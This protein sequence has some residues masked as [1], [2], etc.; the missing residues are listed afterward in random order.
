VTETLSRKI[1]IAFNQYPEQGY[2]PGKLQVGEINVT[3]YEQ[4][5]LIEAKVDINLDVKDRED[6]LFFSLEYCITLFKR[7]TMERF[8]VFPREIAAAVAY[9]KEI[10]LNDIKISHDLLTAVSGVYQSADSEF[11]F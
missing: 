10:K 4:A 8:I 9:N 5:A 2:R 7:G 3:P 11:E 1:A 6:T